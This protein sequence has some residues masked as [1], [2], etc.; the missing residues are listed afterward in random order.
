MER[1]GEGGEEG[2]SEPVVWVALGIWMDVSINSGTGEPSGSPEE[3]E[4]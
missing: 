1:Y 3:S 2:D 4:Y